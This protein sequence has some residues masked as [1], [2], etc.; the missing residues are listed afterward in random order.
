[1]SEVYEPIC[2]ERI[3]VP[4]DNSS[5]SLAALKAAVELARH[6]DAEL[7]GIFVEDINLLKLAEMPFHQEV[8]QYTAIIREISA[9]GLSR[10]IFVQSRWVVQ[11]FRRL[12]NQTDINADF[13]VLKGDVSET[14]ERESQECD[15]VIIGKSGKN[16]LAKGRL[17]ST[18]KVMIQHHR[19][20][21]LLVEENDQLGYPI[22]LL[23]EN[24]PIG[25][26]SLETARDL[27]DPDETLVVL[28]NKDDPETYSESEIYIKK[29][30]S[31]HH[32]SISVETFRAHTFSRFIH[33]I[34]GMKNGLFILP[35]S[36]DPINQAIAEICLDKISL[37]V[38]LIRIN[39]QQ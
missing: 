16:I 24:S 26:I 19:T 21:L 32:V 7:R 8:G 27:L 1:M 11:S 18:A 4:L 37:P 10:G 9:D 35:H 6:Y 3:L 39:N 25:K 36:A 15:L 29:W 33:M 2:V 22:I 5:H 14:I 13:V 23:F 30:A 31:A 12:I 17:G 38:L 34:A 20:P 28:L